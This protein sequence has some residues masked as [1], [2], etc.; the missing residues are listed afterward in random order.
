MRSLLET[1]GMADDTHSVCIPQRRP[2]TQPKAIAGASVAVK[3]NNA[4]AQRGQ[5]T[6]LREDP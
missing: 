3:A 2:R 6:S 5:G 4:C 1:D